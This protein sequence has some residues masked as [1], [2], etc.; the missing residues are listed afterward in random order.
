MAE[1]IAVPQRL[2][3]PCWTDANLEATIRTVAA[4]GDES[5]SRFLAT[6]APITRVRIGD[7]DRTLSDAKVFESIARLSARENVVLVHGAPGTG[8]SH[9]INWIKLRYDH[10]VEIGEQS[11][12]MPV[13]V[14]R[15][16]GSLKDALEQLVEQLPERF[17]TYL[18]PVQTA[19]DRISEKEARKK[20]ATELHLELGIRREEAGKERLPRT[21]RHLAEAF[22]AEGFGAWLCREGGVIDRNI[23]Q[24]IS[25]SEVHDRESFPRFTAEEFRISNPQQ[26]SRGLNTDNV[27]RLI[28]ELEDEP[29]S[30]E[31]AAALCNESLRGALRE[32]M[33]LGNAALSTILRGIRQDLRKE[34]MRLILLIEDVSTLSVLDDEVV[35]AVEPQD[36]ASLCDLT[37]VLGMTEQAYQRLRDNQ[38]QRIAGSGLIL[39][40]PKDASADAWVDDD[41]QIDRFVARYLNAARLSDINVEQ[42]ADRRRKSGDVGLSACDDCPVRESCH[43]AFGSVA[44]DPDTVVGLFPFRPGTAHYLL[45]NLDS[46]QIGVRPTQRGLLDHVTKPVMRY[47]SAVADGERHALTLPVNRR[48][49]TDWQTL[50]EIFL[51]GWAQI[52]R[53]RYRLLA[54]A[55]TPKVRAADIAGDLRSLLKPFSLP[56][57]SA[58]APAA[59]P[60][61]SVGASAQTQAADVSPAQTAPSPESPSPATPVDAALQKRLDGLL[62][63]LDRWMNNDKLETPRDYQDVLI[64][65]LKGA[66]PLE[67]IRSPAIPAQRKLRDAD[68]G[69]IRIEDATTQATPNRISF[70]FARSEDTLQLIRALIH[71]DIEGGGSW[72]FPG[73]ERYKRIVARWLRTHQSTMMAALDP[74]GLSP[75]LPIKHA[76]KFL[77][78]ASMVERRAG[79]PADTPAALSY[80]TS[81]AD[82]IPP[83]V[84]TEPLRKLY[85]DLPDRRRMLQSFVVEETN[86][87]QGRGGI[88]VIDPQIITEAITEARSNPSIAPLPAEYATSYWKSR[89]QAFDGLRAW[90]ALPDAIAVERAAIGDMVG[91]VDRVL[92]RYGFPAGGDYAG[93]VAYFAEVG[94]LFDLLKQ[95]FRWTANEIDFFK[96]ERM[97]DRS[98]SFAKILA[99]AAVVAEGCE[100]SE[101]LQ[102]DP[103][104]LQMVAA[105]IDR[106]RAIIDDA[107]RFADDKLAHLSAEGDPDL[108][109][110]EIIAE[111]LRLNGSAEVAA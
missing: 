82:T 19:I 102:F 68:R 101:V 91:E 32:L 17:H 62:N 78:V 22:H 35:N 106:C 41:A 81:T 6:H 46:T 79:L 5:A 95:A 61:S 21:I 50:T 31:Q 2:G 12:V 100:V 105:Y 15:R 11:G 109:E 60:V 58:K 43:A 4:M 67:D 71:H 84:L 18:E 59:A 77:C 54:E 94:R 55:W 93:C 80:V 30:A 92:A 75:T 1:P 73:A 108:I 48:P 36:D 76:T 107:G 51:G 65:F 69:S 24:L 20:L 74:D 40:F 103:N 33:G 10:A 28:D 26:R 70:H 45:D 38:Y 96:R 99:K 86:L 8:K 44:F 104:D 14:R 66:L 23:Q 53:E 97:I 89:Y 9:L 42:I 13:L 27:L 98:E 87:P 16:T 3:E 39:S 34:N 7:T 64:K 111:L 72:N 63:R 37:A 83:T 88:V 57:Y 47:V 29:K 52:E 90:A 25:P 56:D 49:P 110:Q 85:A